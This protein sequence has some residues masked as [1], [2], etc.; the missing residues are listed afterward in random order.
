VTVI[1]PTY[2][3]AES[4][5][6]LL[7][8]LGAL[9]ARAGLDLELLVMDDDSRDGVVEL[10]AARALPWVRLVVRKGDRGLSAAV[11]DGL[12]LATKDV[13]VVMDADLSHPP[14][15]IP[16]LLEALAQG[17]D[18]VIGSR[19][20]A[21]ASTAED[22]GASRWLNSRIA[23]WLARPLT[24]VSDPMSG[25]FA[26][27]RSTLERADPLNPIG[28]KIGLELIVKCRARRTAEV[29]IHFA[30]RKK[31]ESKLTFREQLRY[32][33]HLRRL[34]IHRFPQ[35]SALAQ[36]L[37]VGASGV[38]VNLLALTA[39]LHLGVGVRTAVALGIAVSML[40]NFALDRRFTFSYAR[41]GRV[42]RQLAGFVAASSVGAALN[43]AVAVS[44]LATWPRLLPQLAACAGIAAGTGINFLACRTLVFQ[45]RHAPQE[46]PYRRD[47]SVG[48]GRPV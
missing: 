48:S 19:Y 36:F 1:V 15:R 42:P 39:L 4:L 35:A 21:G 38:V 37:V 33:Q 7:D 32:V 43:Y 11:A 17:H 24:R 3:E 27:R 8:R 26:L 5:P 13:V 40:S 45:R 22:W 12:R 23:T 6:E 2:R 34:Y 9:R 14:E 41:H 29:P 25:F 47:A 28:Y 10:V 18:L 30:Q 46:A 16:A 20:A 31:G 44:L